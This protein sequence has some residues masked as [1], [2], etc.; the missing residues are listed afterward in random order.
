MWIGL[1]SILLAMFILLQGIAQAAEVP[2][3]SF[4]VADLQGN[5]VSSDLLGK[6]DP[7]VLVV[8]APKNKPSQTLLDG[9][10]TSKVTWTDRVIIVVTGDQAKLEAMKKQNSKLENVHWYRDVDNNI[11][12]N[13]GLSGWP[14]VLGV[15]PGHSIAWRSMGAPAT[16]LAT[17]SMVANWIGLVLKP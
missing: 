11:M 8:V 16:T 3:P 13:L 4:T 17:Q 9:L 7:W 12:R 14:A 15:V 10:Q 1:R 5:I 6:A 2:L